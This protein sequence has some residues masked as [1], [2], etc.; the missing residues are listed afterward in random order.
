M[1]INTIVNMVM[2]RLM[3]Q[4]VDHAF[5]KSGELMNR[6]R[7]PQQPVDPLARREAEL[8]AREQAL[9]RI[10]REEELARREADIARREQEARNRQG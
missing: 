10:A 1:N 2:R 5:R 4:G 9:A 8:Q 7:Q 3:R 6:A